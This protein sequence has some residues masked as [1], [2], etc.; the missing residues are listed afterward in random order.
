MDLR[1]VILLEH[2]KKQCESI[3]RY[4][5]KDQKRFD[6]LADLFFND[7]YRVIQ[8]AA[9]PLS[10][11]VI[12]HPELIRKHLN[13]IIRNL[14]KPG[15]HNAV[16]RNTIRLL[17]SVEIPE[18]LHG[19]IM[20]ICF[21]YIADPKEMVAVKAFSLTVLANLANQ[22]PEIIPELKLIIE[23]QLPHETAAFKSRAK[24]ILKQFDNGK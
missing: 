10:Y 22:Y 7:E 8:R 16:K 5:G 14:K 20:D 2:S 9:W 4:I 19:E 1:A 15:I 12:A 24:K 13:K 6:A 11:S 23:D 17:Q 3:V 18:S 21:Q